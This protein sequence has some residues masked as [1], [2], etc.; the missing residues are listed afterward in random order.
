MLFELFRISMTLRKQIDFQE[1]RSISGETPTREEWLRHIFS[2]PLIFPSRGNGSPFHYSPIEPLLGTNSVAGRIG[3]QTV[4]KESSA[5]QDGFQPIEREQWHAAEVLID[6]TH[7]ADGQKLAMKVK[8]IV[9]APQGILAA[10][11]AYLNSQ[12][13]APYVIEIGA[14]SDPESFWD[15]ARQ[16]PGRITS[17]TLEAPVPNMFGHE[18]DYDDELRKYRDQ[19]KAQK[20]AITIKNPD[21]LN[22]ETPTIRNGVSYAA[23][24]GGKINAK[25][26]GR[27]PYSSDR[28]TMR[29]SS[30]SITD[31]DSDPGNKIILYIKASFERGAEK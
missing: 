29:I 23:K 6:P 4:E 13:E 14:I 2:R 26:K 21:G 15:Y 10:L 30:E 12:A 16:N 25:A 3:R 7:H 5:P 9:G 1:A 8:S 22:V 17:L 18:N 24:S 19:E 20:V 11:V 31:Q 27:H 28:K